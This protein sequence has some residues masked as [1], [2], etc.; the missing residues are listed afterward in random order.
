[1]NVQDMLDAMAEYGFEDTSLQ[2][3][4]AAIQ[5]AIWGIEGMRPWPFLEMSTL[6]NFDGTSDTPS[7]W[8]AQPFRAMIRMKDLVTGRRILPIR[9]EDFED[10]VGMNYAQAGDPE[11]YY[12]EANQLKV[13]PIPPVS[14]GRIKAR[15]IQWSAPIT[16]SSVESALLIP[17]YYHEA[18]VLNDALGRL[19]DMEDDS[20]LSAR[21]EGHRDKALAEAVEALFM[22]QY[23]R[24]DAVV[25]TD[26]DDWDNCY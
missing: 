19:Y 26:P 15:F 3:K 17:R 18:L 9:V 2:R 14:T 16:D 5:A 25:V 8:A 22:R 10:R 23:D 21:F 13:W 11:V 24:G 12:F 7:N 6:L 20:E 4:V 1:V